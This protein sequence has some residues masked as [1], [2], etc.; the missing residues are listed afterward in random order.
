VI[1]RS[2]ANLDSSD[3]HIHY[4]NPNQLAEQIERVLAELER[5]GF[6]DSSKGVFQQK[7]LPEND[8]DGLIQ[9]LEPDLTDFEQEWQQDRRRR[10]SITYISGSTAFHCVWTQ[11]RLQSPPRTRGDTHDGT[12][13]V[14]QLFVPVCCD[15]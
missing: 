6:A 3:Q 11:F 4:G 5:D 8:I 2:E 9:F 12:G 7:K 13:R 14:L 10:Q 1:V 15:Y